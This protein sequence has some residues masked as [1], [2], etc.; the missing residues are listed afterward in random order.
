MLF[1]IFN[2][3]LVANGQKVLSYLASIFHGRS[4]DQFSLSFLHD[5]VEQSLP[6]MII[7]AAVAHNLK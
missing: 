6:E 2:I 7:D 4:V 5:H 3:F 1:N